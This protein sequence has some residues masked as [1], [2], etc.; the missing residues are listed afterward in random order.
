MAR[1]E[2]WDSMRHWDLVLPPS[3]P[4][5]FQLS[6]IRYQI[7][8]FGRDAPVGILGSTPEFRD[9]LYEMGFENVTILERNCDFY[10]A[11]S[12]LRVYSNSESILWGDWMETLSKCEDQFQIVL[13]DL[14]SGNIHYNERSAFYGLIE[15]SLRK[16]GIFIDKLLTH[17]GPNMS[18]QLIIDKYSE[19]PLNLQFINYFSCEAI[20]CS[21]LLDETQEIDTDVFYLSLKECS[22]NRRFQAF[23]ERAKMITPEGCKWYYGVPWDELSANYCPRLRKLWE[24]D[25]E[26]W[27]PYA[28][29]LK[30][31]C[32]INP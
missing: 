29:R 13:S 27:S 28:G 2:T 14:T 22:A 4:S 12:G 8:G 1:R 20:F 32:H 23:V 9:L 26:P 25:E 30:Y 19:L 31:V 6:K 10:N 15:N 5:N 11:C 7:Q 3:R 16:G 21:E 24:L 18:L 17:P